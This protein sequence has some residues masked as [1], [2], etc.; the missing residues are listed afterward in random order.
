M[1]NLNYS[2]L[3]KRGDAQ[4]LYN[5]IWASQITTAKRKQLKFGMDDFTGFSWRGVDA[6]DNFGAFIINNKNSLKFYGGSTYSNQYT[7]PQ[8]ESSTGTLTGISFN[9]PKIDFTIG[10]Y[11]ISEDDYRQLIYWLNPYEI[12]ALTFD[13]EPNYYYQVKLA[14]VEQ[15][16]RYIVGTEKNYDIEY[17]NSSPFSLWLMQFLTEKGKCIRVKMTWENSDPYITLNDQRLYKNRV[18]QI[19]RVN[20]DQYIDKRYQV[21]TIGH[22]VEK[23]YRYYTEFKVSFEVQGPACAYHKM[24]YEF[25]YTTD[26]DELGK[27][28]IQTWKVKSENFHQIGNSNLE[29]PFNWYI[30]IS[31]NE[32]FQPDQQLTDLI[33]LKI[34]GSIYYEGQTRKVLFDTSL[35]NLSFLNNTP[36]YSPENRVWTLDLKYD[37]NSGLMFL[38]L[39]NNDRLLLSRLSTVSTGKRIINSIIVEKH[40]L[41][42]NFESYIFDLSKVTLTLEIKAFL[43]LPNGDQIELQLR[44]GN[45]QQEEGIFAANHIG[46][47][48][49]RARTNL[50]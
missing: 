20:D 1:P 5:N 29:M 8:F 18:Y 38:E 46:Y 9:T 39:G 19:I 7:K 21:T 4:R 17:D 16:I 31:L 32:I 28:L 43:Q 36:D 40:F 42:G 12:S 49:M 33:T 24:A 26:Y 44:K 15:G 47:I 6:F 11:W 30:P 35:T 14:S 45:Q 50:I 25:N 10:A 2:N 41:S 34:T 13:F 27:G 37:S 3:G 23:D 48:D 22:A